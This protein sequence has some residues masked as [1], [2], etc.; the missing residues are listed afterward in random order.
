MLVI[1][2][3]PDSSARRPGRPPGARCAVTH[4][5]RLGVHHFAFLRAIAQGLDERHAAT[6][7]LNLDRV[8]ER[9]VKTETK[10][11]KAQVRMQCSGD[12]GL[13][14]IA[15]DIVFEPP[16]AARGVSL[17]DLPMDI[18]PDM[19]S[20]RE[21][22]ELLS[23]QLEYCVAGARDIRST[24]RALETVQARLA[25]LAKGEDALEKWIAPRLAQRLRT[26][27][28]LSLNDILSFAKIHGSTWHRLVAGVGKDKAQRLLRWVTTI[29]DL[30]QQ[31][32]KITCKVQVQHSV[33]SRAIVPLERLDVPG[34]LS[35]N[36]GVFRA[37]GQV[38]SLGAENDMHAIQAWLSLLADRS[39]HTAR[40]YRLEIERFYLWAQL[41]R[42]KPLSSLDALDCQAYL[43]F[44]AAPPASW[45]Q[46]LP[47][48]RGHSDW[49]PFRGALDAASR[50]RCL[51]AVGRLFSDLLAS[52]YLRVN[53]MPRLRATPAGSLVKTVIPHSLS[54]E[55]QSVLIDLV[56]RDGDGG[57]RLRLVA[58]LKLLLSCGLR[59]AEAVALTTEHLIVLRDGLHESQQ[60]GIRVIGKGNKERV[61]P[62]R[63]D[64]WQ[65]LQAHHADVLGKVE[66]GVVLE[67]C[68]HPLILPFD[69]SRH[70]IKHMSAGRLYDIL[71]ALFAK[72]AIECE[73]RGLSSI[74]EASTH[75][76]R[77]TFAQDVMASSERDI[78]LVQQLLGHS[79][80][81]TTTIYI[82]TDMNNRV[83]AVKALASPVLTA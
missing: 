59:A 81:Q 25:A 30:P 62:L 22:V 42:H 76:L 37:L 10:R 69:C 21:L 2:V 9:I 51:A 41:E 4:E 16:T 24:L 34:W 45:V 67:P 26:S 66:Q 50:Q 5:Q 80:I 33:L 27:G 36:D 8:D 58:I 64:V 55:H 79:N 63:D 68:F 6:R 73:Q 11:I 56:M 70:D 19:Y 72:A 44:I 39:P 61:L 31:E 14:A 1:A 29:L 49:R 82:E 12:P 74:H 47:R 83:Q 32:D 13:Q 7:Y 78:R 54:I 60:R 38:N 40:A 23:Q 71:K 17:D 57:R 3:Q 20:E 77:H 65:S 48:G 52:G 75:W 35:G 28:I 53:P 15:D 43:A 46:A 18:D